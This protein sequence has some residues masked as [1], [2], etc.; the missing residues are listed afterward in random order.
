MGKLTGI[1]LALT[2]IATIAL[3]GYGVWFALVMNL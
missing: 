2:S 1:T 3:C